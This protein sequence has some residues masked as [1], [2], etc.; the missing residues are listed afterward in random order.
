M[1]RELLHQ[2]APR[3][4]ELPPLGR[5]WVRI[6]TALD[7]VESEGKQVGWYLVRFLC[8]EDGSPMFREDEQAE[9]MRMPAWAATRVVEEV[10][11]LMQPPPHPGEALAD[12]P[13]PQARHDAGGDG[14]ADS[15]GA[16][17]MAAA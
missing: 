9:A 17:G 14:E 16:V 8:D 1:R 3:P 5:A 10:G 2:R 7:A 11:R 4:L 13:R 15:V 6:P 12:A